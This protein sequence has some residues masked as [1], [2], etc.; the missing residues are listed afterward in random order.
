MAAPTGTGTHIPDGH[1]EMDQNSF[2]GDPKRH[3]SC[4][5]NCLAPECCLP[6]LAVALGTGYFITF[7]NCTSKELIN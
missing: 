7:L 5:T 3:F 6:L 1:C 2:A 4:L